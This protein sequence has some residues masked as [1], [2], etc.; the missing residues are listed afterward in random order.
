MEFDVNQL[1]I[2]IKTSF[3]NYLRSL[4]VLTKA[5]VDDLGCDLSFLKH[6]CLVKR[7]NFFCFGGS[8]V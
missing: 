2:F 8:D 3:M 4:M 1:G 7:D 6:F 5:S